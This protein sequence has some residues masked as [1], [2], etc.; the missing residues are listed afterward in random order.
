MTSPS[1]IR[2]LFVIA[3]LALAA[4]APGARAQAYPDKPVRLIVNSAAGGALDATARNLAEKLSVRMGKP[5]IVENRPGAGG[6]LGANSVAKSPADGYTLLFVSAGYSM[7]PALYTDLPFKHADLTPVAVAVA[8]PFV[9]VTSPNA[10]YKT[11]PEFIAYAKSQPGK[12]SF[13]SGGNAT[14][15]HL[16]GTWFKAEAGI[17]LLHVPFRGEGPAVQSLLGEQVPIMPVTTTIGLPLIKAGKLRALAIS[18]AKRSSLLPDVP[19]IAEQGVPVQ[20]VTWFG[21]MAPA[22]VPKEIVARLNEAVNQALQEPD[23]RDKYVGA[24]ME[25]GGGSQADFQKLIERETA[26]WARLIKDAGIKTE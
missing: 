19:T 6:V 1:K 26:H 24:G 7:L 11:L 4:T 21:M 9:L 20:S 8:V 5:F 13:A 18:S 14:A 17:D 25:V 12:L 3:P 15:G 2:R 23:L 22:G 10:P 16:L